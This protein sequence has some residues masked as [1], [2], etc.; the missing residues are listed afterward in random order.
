MSRAELP[1]LYELRDCIDDPAS[2]DAYFQN[3]DQNLAD[4]GHIGEI[5]RRWE[6]LLEGLDAKAWEHLK[7]EATPRLT[8]RDKMGRGWQQLF[9]ILNEAR[10]Y[11]YLKSIGCTG[12]QFVPRSS[13]RSP[14]LEADLASDRVLCEVKSLNRSDEEVAAQ[15]GPPKARSG[16]INLGP[17]FLKKLLAAVETAN[18]QMSAHDPAGAAVH[19]VYLNVAFDDFFAERKEAYFQ[20]IDEYLATAPVSDSRIVICNDRTAFYKPLQMRFAHVDNAG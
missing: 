15:K 7:K 10:A 6:R 18:R 14:D 4:S 12:V 1:R 19:V 11:N 5:Y 3:F 13:E 9:D 17:G 2:P 20:Q 8:Q 16:Q